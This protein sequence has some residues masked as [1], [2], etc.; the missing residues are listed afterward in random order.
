MVLSAICEH[1]WDYFQLYY[2]ITLHIFAGYGLRVAI[3]NTH[4]WMVDI[5]GRL[6][7]RQRAVI[8]A[9]LS[10]MAQALVTLEAVERIVAHAAATLFAIVSTFIA[11][12]YTP[13]R[14]R[15]RR[16]DRSPAPYSY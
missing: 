12:P 10:V 6:K 5:L 16:R 14:Q 7:A 15:H 1:M 4:L 11:Q 3:E 2:F 9:A 8:D 13:S